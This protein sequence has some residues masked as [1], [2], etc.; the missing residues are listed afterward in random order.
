MALPVRATYRQDADYFLEAQTQ[1]RYGAKPLISEKAQRR[2]F[3]VLIL[4]TVT[5]VSVREGIKRHM[6]LFPLVSAVGCLL[7]MAFWFWLFKKIG[8][9]NAGSAYWKPTEKDRLRLQKSLGKMAEQELLVSWEFD[10]TGVRFTPVTEK[11][12]N[13]S[14]PNV[15]RV[16]ETPRGLLIFMNR[17]SNLWFPK[18]A[19]ASSGDYEEVCRIIAARAGTFQ[20]LTPGAWAYVALGSNLGDS[21]KEVLK[22]MDKL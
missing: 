2:F 21:K 20:R 19:F 4:G 7:I 6:F 16:V 1:G 13:Y 14:W 3:L 17:I 18:T 5:V 11:S 12:V 8:L 22:A 10:E 15:S 9:D